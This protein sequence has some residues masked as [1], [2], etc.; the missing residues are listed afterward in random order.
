MDSVFV[1]SWPAL[2]LAMCVAIF[3]TLAIRKWQQKFMLPRLNFSNLSVFQKG[4][5]TF[6]QRLIPILPLLK[7]VAFALFLFAFA[8]PHL[9]VASRNEH[10]QSEE[11]KESDGE[12]IEEVEVP[13]KGVAIY[14]VLDQSSSMRQKVRV[15]SSK[16]RVVRMTRLD[17]LKQVTRDFILGSDG[18]GLGGRKNDMVGLVGFARVAQVLCPLT[19]QHEYLLEKLSKLNLYSDES[20]NGTAIGY[21]IFK[22]ANL[23]AATE[24]Y[25]KDLIKEGKPSYEIENTV[26]VLVT[27]GIQE[28][29]PLDRSHRYR[30]MSIPD[31]ARYATDKGVRLYV[32]NIE[33]MIKQREY[34]RERE[35]LEY[36]AR[37][38]G[39][40]F[41][42]ADQYSSLQQIYQEI[43]SLEKSELPQG[44]KVQAIVE[45]NILERKDSEHWER[46]SFYPFLIGMG[47]L[48]L[49]TAVM[50]DSTYL[51]RVP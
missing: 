9:L 1:I 25:A 36:A 46:V 40:R 20:E 51:R 11:K 21:A 31:A 15:E 41:F 30:A 27:D 48:C 42:V 37:S 49:F 19:L 4:E 23:I 34:S 10:S 39:G 12:K 2:G 44:K 28:T 6:R 33:P 14:L 18:E 47:M 29:N 50:L 43:D 45:E 22:T 5:K 3:V 24:H 17:H 8:D 26:I 32:V 16:G 7:A 13:T 35:E 38:T